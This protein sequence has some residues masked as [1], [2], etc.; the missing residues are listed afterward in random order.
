MLEGR[1]VKAVAGFYYVA[2]EESGI[3]MC[4][5][6][7][8][9]R[10]LGIRPLVG[11]F[12]SIEV[13]HEGDMEGNVVEI[14]PR[15]NELLRPAAANVDACLA[16]F[17]VKDPDPSLILVDRFLLQAARRGIPAAVCFNKTDLAD[18]GERRRLQEA[19]GKC[20]AAVIF[21]SFERGEGIDE[22]R[23]YVKGRTV[24]LAGPSGVGKSTL[25]NILTGE[26]SM[27]TGSVSKKLGRGRHTTRHTEIFPLGGGTYILDTPGFAELFTDD[28]S[29]EEL[30]L[31]YPEFGNL[32]EECRFAGCAHLKEPDCA[33]RREVL[34]G[35]I[36]RERYESYCRIYEDLAEREK[37]RY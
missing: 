29:K 27:E 22:A 8:V 37:N 35:N 16:V 30:Q 10:K 19:Y 34:A 5:A 31:Y 9:F 7:G 21:T 24:L 36:S 20:G 13:T 17:A 23:A 14:H 2:V 28:V 32:A 12:A 3:Y 6:K 33:V 4:R 18:E 11:D 1:I 26:S 25:T 15:S